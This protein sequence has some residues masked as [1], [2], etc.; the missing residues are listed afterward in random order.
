V[1]ICL[2]RFRYCTGDNTS[3]AVADTYLLSGVVSYLCCNRFKPYRIASVGI[4]S[5]HAVP[6][7]WICPECKK[8][9]AGD[10]ADNGRSSADADCDLTWRSADRYRPMTPLD[11][12]AVMAELKARDERA[13][14]AVTVNA[15]QSNTG[16]ETTNVLTVVAADAV[17]AGSSEAAKDST[18]AAPMKPS[19]GLGSAAAS[20]S[21]RAKEDR[22]PIAVTPAS[23]SHGMRTGYET[24]G[25]CVDRTNSS[26]DGVTQA[27]ASGVPSSVIACDCLKGSRLED[28]HHLFRFEGA[29]SKDAELGKDSIAAGGDRVPFDAHRETASSSGISAYSDGV[30]IRFAGDD[31]VFGSSPTPST[32]RASTATAGTSAAMVN[33]GEVVLPPPVVDLRPVAALTTLNNLTTSDRSDRASVVRASNANEQ[34]RLRIL[35]GALSAGAQGKRGRKGVREFAL[36]ERRA[37]FG[38]S[39]DDAHQHDQLQPIISV[40]NG[41]VR[42]IYLSQTDKDVSEAVE[43]SVQRR[44]ELLAA[45]PRGDAP[46]PAAPFAPDDEGELSGITPAAVS[47]PVPN[48]EHNKIAG[49]HRETD[50][51]TLRCKAVSPM[52]SCYGPERHAFG[53]TALPHGEGPAPAA[54]VQVYFIPSTDNDT[55]IEDGAERRTDTAAPSLP[56]CQASE[57]PRLTAN[58]DVDDMFL[59]STN[60]RIASDT[61]ASFAL[62]SVAGPFVNRRGPL[63]GLAPLPLTLPPQHSTGEGLEEAPALR[64]GRSSL[65]LPPLRGGGV[66]GKSKLPPLGGTVT[67]GATSSA[68]TVPMLPPINV[69]SGTPPRELV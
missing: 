53:S 3:D 69:R 55:P 16:G 59:A 54:K 47:V 46:R 40:D 41:P 2:S 7:D 60:R 57:G 13:R 8:S 6:A 22:D 12:V 64:Q 38:S 44:D 11:P 43:R 65:T 45:L 10:S 51:P 25:E 52:G 68:S 14:R 49:E 29:V 63:G 19:A 42:V 4:S 61:A 9:I 36:L 39:Q 21:P 50:A 35:Q 31:S 15:S 18:A 17:V 26:P 1:I 62:C 34:R 33:S 23:S 66:S 30:D 67:L 56:L 48:R 37:T 28:D 27:N 58:C 24:A 5:T 20:V 32:S